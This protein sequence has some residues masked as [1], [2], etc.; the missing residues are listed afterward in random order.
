MQ[1]SVPNDLRAASAMPFGVKHN[2]ERLHHPQQ[3]APARDRGQVDD[4]RLSEGVVDLSVGMV[5]LAV[6]APGV[7]A[8]QH[9]NAVSGAHGDL[10]RGNTRVQPERDRRM[11]Q[12]VRTGSQ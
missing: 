9:L 1:G 10:R 4:L 11:P 5:V 7:D 2:P 3:E 12:V 6:H 8:E